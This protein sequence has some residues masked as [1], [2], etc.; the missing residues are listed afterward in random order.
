MQARSY[1]LKVG[2][3]YNFC[4]CICHCLILGIGIHPTIISEAFQKAADKGVEILHD[5]SVRVDLSER[6][7]LLKSANTAL[8][9]KVCPCTH[10]LCYIRDFAMIN[11]YIC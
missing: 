9:S 7:S 3:F 11:D 4:G 6:E 2:T 1:S 5:M 10:G 8:N